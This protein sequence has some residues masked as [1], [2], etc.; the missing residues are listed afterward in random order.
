MVL[1]SSA[2]GKIEDADNQITDPEGVDI[3]LEW[4]NNAS[5]PTTGTDLELYIRQ[6]YKSLLSSVKYNAFETIGIT[7]DLLNDGNYSVEVYVDDIDRPTNYSVIVTGK[8]T[9][10]TYKQS[11]GPINANDV[12]STLKPLTLKVEGDRYSVF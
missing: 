8:S 11:F 5:S 3:A 1:F 12:N 6:D 4:T 9:G 7:P 10:K 2:C